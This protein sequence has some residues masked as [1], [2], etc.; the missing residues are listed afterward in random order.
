M[1]E[2]K[3]QQGSNKFL[4]PDGQEDN[5]VVDTGNDDGDGDGDRE[6]K[7]K[8]E[9]CDVEEGDEKADTNEKKDDVDDDETASSPEVNFTH[10]TPSRKAD[11]NEEED[12]DDETAHLPTLDFSHETSSREYLFVLFLGL[13]M[14][15]IAGYSNGVCLS[16]YLHVTKTMLRKQSVTGV[17]GIYTASAIALGK[18]TYSTTR[19]QL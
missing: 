2:D 14:A 9:I 19:I 7:V 10:E 8:F 17:T 12:D 15:F 5:A 16:G 1:A 4:I 3:E 6:T 18:G 11:T 13:T